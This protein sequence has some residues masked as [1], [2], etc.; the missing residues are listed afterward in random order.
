MTI[1]VWVSIPVRV[2]VTDLGEGLRET[3]VSLP[4]GTPIYVESFGDEGPG[5]FEIIDELV[6]D[7]G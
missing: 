2:K 6:E 7:E 1:D 4:D 3:Q 5:I